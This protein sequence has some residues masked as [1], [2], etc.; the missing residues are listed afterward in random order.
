MS[1]FLDT[2]HEVVFFAWLLIFLAQTTLVRTGTGLSSSPWYVIS[3]RG[4]G[5][6]GVWISD[7][8]QQTAQKLATTLVTRMANEQNTDDASSALAHGLSA[9]NGKIDQQIAQKFATT[10][11][12]RMSQVKYAVELDHLALALS[13]LQ[14]KHP[15]QTIE[16]AT[17]TL[18]AR[19]GQE[20]D[21]G[22]LSNL[23]PHLE[24]ETLANDR[25][26]HINRDGDPNLSLHG[27]VTGPHKTP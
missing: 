3:N 7:I 21:A 10:L 16:A 17:P 15:P 1:I 6:S 14:I 4:R 12:T 26:Q 22:A 8:D 5:H 11:V 23:R 25:H 24:P 13:A 19:M 20:K 27:V 9:L 2:V 18:V